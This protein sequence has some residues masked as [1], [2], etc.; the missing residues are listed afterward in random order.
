L[1]SASEF[2]QSKLPDVASCLIFDIG[3]RRSSG[4]EVRADLAAAGLHIPTIFITGRGDIP[5]SVRAMRAG[6]IDFLTKPLRTA[7]F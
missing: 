2:L 3:L 4:L 7:K 5:M 6:A 1:S